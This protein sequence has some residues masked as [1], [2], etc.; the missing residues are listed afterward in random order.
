MNDFR[1]NV[2]KVMVVFLF[3]FVGLISYIAY[4]QTF[5]APKLAEDEG[6]KRIWAERNKIVRGTIYDRNMNALTTGER[7]G[8][9]TQSRKYPFGDLY[10]SSVGY[11]SQTYGLSG[12]EKQ[13]DKQLTTYS[14]VGVGFRTFIKDFS[15]KSLKESFIDRDKEKEKKGN[16]V[17]T[18]LDANIQKAAY[19]A[20]GDNV[21]AVVAINPKTGEVL[22]MVSKPSFD[23]N[24]LEAA[25]K[26]ANSG[27]ANVSFINRATEGAYPPGST[28]KTITTASSLQNISGVEDRIFHDT[29][30]LSLGGSYSLSNASGEVNGDINLKQA[31]AASS[32]VV[33]GT[34]ALELGNDELKATAESFG[35]NN[36]I[37]A[38]GFTIKQ[39]KF[40]TLQS[41][42]KGMIAQCGIGQSEILA[43]PMQMALVA[44]TIANDGIMMEPKLV[45]KVIDMNNNVV[46][47]VDSKQYKQVINPSIA[48]T[49]TDYMTNLVNNNGSMYYFDGYNVAG[50]TG[51]ADHSEAEGAQPHSWFIGFAP[52]DN[53]KIAF[54]VIVENGGWGAQVAAP[55]AGKV[56]SA[57][58][59]NQNS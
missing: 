56:V 29:G 4:F 9:L 5:K 21:G 54:A 55:I 17:V 28:F 36:T 26:A 35:F 32:N 41:Y 44:S 6:N 13:Y 45:N 7:T 19:D 12:L 53:P 20:L 51:T 34:L 47:T 37:P 46:T 39:S 14:S 3:L 23:P 33:Y 49:I 18:T 38:E 10:A 40:P 42:Q 58:L 16:S 43:S 52:A 31:F 59:G 57:A 2:K 48:K 24:N 25:F 8:V 1:S 30:S 15:F 22:A 11:I 27:D 50:K